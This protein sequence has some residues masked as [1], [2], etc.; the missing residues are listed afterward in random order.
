MLEVKTQV[1]GLEGQVLVNNTAC[2][3]LSSVLAVRIG[4]CN[5]DTSMQRMMRVSHCSYNTA[6]VATGVLHCASTV[7]CGIVILCWV[8]CR[9]SVYLFVWTEVA[10]DGCC[11]PSK[12][13]RLK[14]LLHT[15][16]VEWSSAPSTCVSFDFGNI[17]IKQSFVQVT[18]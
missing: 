8:L 4:G 1:L 15:T 17:Q 2:Q 12:S 10:D 13:T 6:L 14:L 3:Y 5:S 11:S 9:F 7:S 16:L 18:L